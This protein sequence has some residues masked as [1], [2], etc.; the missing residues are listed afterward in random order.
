MKNSIKG[1]VFDQKSNV[2]LIGKY[3]F[4]AGKKVA[5]FIRTD[6]TT[7]K[8]NQALFNLAETEFGG[9]DVSSIIRTYCSM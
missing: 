9:V 4:R 5:V 2:I 3:V 6:V 7:Y 1:K 8:D